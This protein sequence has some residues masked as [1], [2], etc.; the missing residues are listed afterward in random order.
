MTEMDAKDV[1]PS[2]D[3]APPR[4]RER[5]LAAGAGRLSDD[6]LIA[7]LLGCGVR[8]RPIGVLSREVLLRAGG[9]PGLA[10]RGL[11]ALA[12]ERGLGPAGCARLAAAF[13]IARRI[14]APGVAR[15]AVRDPDDVVREVRDLAGEP[16]EHLVGL[17]LD[18]N[19]RLIARET[20]AVGSLNV[21]RATPRDLLEPALRWLA[22]GFVI[23]HNHPSGV[24]E[25]SEDD[26]AFTRA[27]GRAA[28]MMGVPLWDHVVVAR[29]GATSLRARGVSWEGQ[30][31]GAA[32]AGKG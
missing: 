8:G 6:E 10:A 19:A 1:P 21:A 24:A 2:T 28:W 11:E 12:S 20:I 26:L 9:L 13:E 7:V 31:A 3:G 30:D 4:L 27:V 22:T 17:Y 18:A 14:A 5:L 15:P 29:S 16:R 32:P 23:V 25:P